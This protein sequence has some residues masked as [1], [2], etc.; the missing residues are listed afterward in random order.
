MSVK[1]MAIQR[2]AIGG[3]VVAGEAFGSMGSTKV[4][5]NDNTYISHT[6]CVE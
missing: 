5:T 2:M 3:N 6:I 1:Q 4:V